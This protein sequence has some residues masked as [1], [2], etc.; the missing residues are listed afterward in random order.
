MNV[1]DFW[2]RMRG[3]FQ[4]LLGESAPKASGAPQQQLLDDLLQQ[5]DVMR[6]E[7]IDQASQRTLETRQEEKLKAEQ[8]L[9]ASHQVEMFADIQEMHQSLATGMDEAMLHALSEEIHGHCQEFRSLHAEHLPQLVT[10]SIARRFHQEALKSGW[11]QLLSLMQQHGVTWPDPDVDPEKLAAA[12]AANLVDCQADFMKSPMVRFADL[13]FG[14]V[15]IWRSVYPRRGGFLWQQTVL[16]SIGGA[17]AAQAHHKIV[18]TAQ[19]RHL[20]IV[21]IL[22]ANLTPKIQEIQQRLAQG[23]TTVTQAQALSDEAVHLCQEHAPELIWQHLQNTLTRH[24]SQ[25]NCLHQGACNS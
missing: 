15:P 19:V 12:K 6:L 9:T 1:S 5:L 22:A 2:A 4:P 23:V 21:D 24:T 7:A 16:F 18:Q 3:Y 13:M 17:L 8:E 25:S 11:Q 20:E 10:F 14:L